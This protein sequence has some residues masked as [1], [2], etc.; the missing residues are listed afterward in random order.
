MAHAYSEEQL[1]KQPAIG[2]G[3]S[4]HNFHQA[5]KNT[6]SVLNCLPLVTQSVVFTRRCSDEG[7]FQEA[8]EPAPGLHC[9]GKIQTYLDLAASGERAAEAAEHLFVECIAP[10]WQVA[11]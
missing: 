10:L 7:V 8:V 11:P 5:M 3:S 9:T 2:L 6:D 1:V 4:F